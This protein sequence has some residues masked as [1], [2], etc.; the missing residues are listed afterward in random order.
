M[1]TGRT[2]QSRMCAKLNFPRG[3]I[4]CTVKLAGHCMLTQQMSETLS[5]VGAGRVG[6]ALGRCLH[7]LG[8]RVVVVVT[9]SMPTARAAV[10]AIGAGDATDGLTRQLL[11]SG[12]VLMATPDGVIADVAAELALLGGNEWSGKVVLH[13]SGALDSS[14]LQALADAGAATR[15]MH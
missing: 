6:K 4:F 8:W 1:Q 14:A 10:R 7:D 9:R 11:A 3:R 13:T 5:I 12:V 15:S 2:A